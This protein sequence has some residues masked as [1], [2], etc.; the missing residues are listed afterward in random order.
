MTH[1]S[2]LF[3]EEPA[4]RRALVCVVTRVKVL[5]AV[6]VE[7]S[8]VR[9]IGVWGSERVTLAIAIQKAATFRVFPTPMKKRFQNFASTFER[10]LDS[11]I[12]HVLAF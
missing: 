11:G 6:T 7:Q 5:S 3:A 8:T 9:A 10:S 4:T 12:D 1:T 2:T